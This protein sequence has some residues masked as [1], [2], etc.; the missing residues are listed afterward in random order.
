MEK[1]NRPYLSNCPLRTGRLDSIWVGETGNILCSVWDL[2]FLDTHNPEIATETSSSLK[3]TLQ[4]N[5]VEIPLYTNLKDII[6][7]YDKMSIV[8]KALYLK[9]YKQRDATQD[10]SAIK[11]ILL[12]LA[13]TITDAKFGAY[14]VFHNWAWPNKPSLEALTFAELANKVF[15]NCWVAYTNNGQISIFMDEE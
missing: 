2:D 12:D 14:Q 6:Q 11:K 9:L 7:N 4:W 5:P 13:K 8:E 15:R 10:E 1:T 3:F